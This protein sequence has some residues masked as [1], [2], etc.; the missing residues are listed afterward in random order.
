MRQR[1]KFDIFQNALFFTSV[2]STN[3]EQKS[4]PITVGPIYGKV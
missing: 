1:P 4:L 2:L 3:F